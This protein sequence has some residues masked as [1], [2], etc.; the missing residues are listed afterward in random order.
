M[1]GKFDDD[2]DVWIILLIPG[3][4]ARLPSGPSVFLL[5]Q[6]CRWFLAY[7]I[8]ISIKNMSNKTGARIYDPS[9]REY[10]PKKTLVFAKTGSIN[11]ATGLV[12]LKYHLQTV[13]TKEDTCKYEEV[14]KY[15]QN[16]FPLMYF[17]RNL[18]L[19][20]IL[21][22]YYLHNFLNITE[23]FLS[24][25]IEHTRRKFAGVNTHAEKVTN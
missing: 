10:K 1:C 8:I 4:Q 9:F 14:S 13:L 6:G 5:A 3:T 24:S 15:F 25:G 18:S 20:S 7:K 12:F 23:T 19:F 16:M 2:I 11:S 22:S 21:F 17:A